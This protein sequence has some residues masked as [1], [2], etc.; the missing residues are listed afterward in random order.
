[1]SRFVPEA[2]I[3]ASIRSPRR[4]AMKLVPSS[5]ACA[6]VDR[7][8]ARFTCASFRSCVAWRAPRTSQMVLQRPQILAKHFCGWMLRSQH[9]LF[10]RE[11]ALGERLRLGIAALS[12][13]QQRQVVEVHG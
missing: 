3:A 9:L 7:G 6:T 12:L 13:V 4:R 2:D 8:C 1:M 10:D 11:R 5:H